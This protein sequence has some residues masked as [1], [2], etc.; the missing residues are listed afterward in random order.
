[1][2]GRPSQQ[3]DSIEAA[4]GSEESNKKYAG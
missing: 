3:Q 4:G 1:M 2:E